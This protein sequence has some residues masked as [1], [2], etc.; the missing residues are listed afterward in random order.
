MKGW[1]NNMMRGCRKKL[2]IL[3]AVL[4]LVSCLTACGQKSDSQPIETPQLML[5]TATPIPTETIDIEEQESETEETLNSEEISDTETVDN[6]PAEVLLD[7][8]GTYDSKEDVA[9]YLI[10][11]GSL[12]QNYITKNKARDLGWEGGSV[13]Q[14]AP[15]KCIGGD[16]FGN[17]EGNLP[18]VEGVTYYECDIDTLGKDSRGPKRIIYSSDGWIYY[19]EDHYNTFECLAEGDAR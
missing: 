2:S 15:G 3:F 18:Q 9:L 11:Y 13:E 19:T 16:R 5:E 6:E 7:K 12:P 8:D 1:K 10:Q 14:F 4:I 17:Y